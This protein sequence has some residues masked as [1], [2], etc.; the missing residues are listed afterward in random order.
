MKGDSCVE[1]GKK[2]KKVV[3]V[4]KKWKGEEVMKKKVVAGL[5]V[6]GG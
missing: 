5:V 3:L 1:R 4:R 6:H 2:E